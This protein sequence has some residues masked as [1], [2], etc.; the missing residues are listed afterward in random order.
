MTITPDLAEIAEAFDQMSGAG[1]SQP[2]M[3]AAGY[4]AETF[5]LLAEEHDTC[6]SSYCLVCWHIRKALAVIAARDMYTAQP[7][8]NRG[9]DSR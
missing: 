5:R 9:G 4:L 8:S 7:G 2:D 3:F 1:V 6:D